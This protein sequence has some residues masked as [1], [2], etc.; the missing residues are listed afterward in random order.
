[1]EEIIGLLKEIVKQ[2]LERCKKNKIVPSKEI[3]D[4]IN[5]IMT[6]EFARLK[7]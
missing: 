2:E 6:Y 3:L 1:M 5:R 4:T 7:N